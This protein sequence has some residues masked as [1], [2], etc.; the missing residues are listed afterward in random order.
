MAG[1]LL[2]LVGTIVAMFLL[3]AELALIALWVFPASFAAMAVWGRVA[4]P[5]F[6]RTRDTIAAC[7][8]TCRSRSAASSVVR[9]FGQ[10]AR[11]RD[12][13]RS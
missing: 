9:S 3:D 5:L 10:E 13:S 4:R 2:A 8:P 12:A 11:H 7:P 6:R 1:S